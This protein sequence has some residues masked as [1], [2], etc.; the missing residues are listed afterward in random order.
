[1]SKGPKLSGQDTEEDKRVIV[2]HSPLVFVHMHVFIATVTSNTCALFC[3]IF[4]KGPEHLRIWYLR[5]KG[6]VCPGTS[7]P[8][9]PREHYIPF[10]IC[11]INVSMYICRTQIIAY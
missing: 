1:M 3:N 7:P 10:S 2:A 5:Q 11:V 6:M 4:Y 9:I 8:Q